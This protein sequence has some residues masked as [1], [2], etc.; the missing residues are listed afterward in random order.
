[1]SYIVVIDDERTSRHV[2]Q[3]SDD[4]NREWT[5]STTLTK[6]LLPTWEPA[7]RV[8]RRHPSEMASKARGGD[9]GSSLRANRM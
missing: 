9:N 2:M 3:E 1:M 5:N 7:P 8:W 6:L 4:R